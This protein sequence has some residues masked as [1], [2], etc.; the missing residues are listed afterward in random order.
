MAVSVNEMWSHMQCIGQAAFMTHDV[1]MYAYIACLHVCT[2][3]L[4]SCCNELDCGEHLL[5]LNLHFAGFVIFKHPAV[6]YALQYN[7]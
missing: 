2:V 6:V 4:V 3:L 1:P 7:K 5:H